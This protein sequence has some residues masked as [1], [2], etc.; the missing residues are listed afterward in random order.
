MSALPLL[1][2][3]STHNPSGL[4]SSRLLVISAA[5][6]SA[7]LGAHSPTLVKAWP[8]QPSRKSETAGGDAN[9]AAMACSAQDRELSRRKNRVRPQSPAATGDTK[10][11]SCPTCE[12]EAPTVR[13][14]NRCLRTRAARHT[15]PTH[16]PWPV[17]TGGAPRGGCSL[18]HRELPRGHGEPRH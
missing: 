16:R 2:P 1:S 17:L 15:R 8:D 4:M 6:C 5:S 13:T 14:E 9:P 10:S 11:C 12:S 7:F 18:P 3:D